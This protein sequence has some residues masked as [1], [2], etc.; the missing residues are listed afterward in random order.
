MMNV[1]HYGV[2]NSC[3]EQADPP[4]EC[5]QLLSAAGGPGEIH[6]VVASIRGHNKP[7]PAACVSHSIMVD[8][9]TGSK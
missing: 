4:E 3:H 8:S 6:T 7:T 1:R 9:K 5:E 2:M